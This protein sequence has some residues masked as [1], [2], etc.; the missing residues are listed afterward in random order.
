MW[1]AY[2]HNAVLELNG[3]VIK[4]ELIEKRYTWKVQQ[5]MLVFSG[6]YKSL[7]INVP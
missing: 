3:G 4:K 2:C 7:T 6:V 1:D 5:N